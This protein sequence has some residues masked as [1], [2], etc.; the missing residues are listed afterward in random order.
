[1]SVLEDDGN[2]IEAMVAAAAA[3]AVTYPH[4]NALGGDNFWLIHAPG[5][6]VIGIDACG[7][8]AGLA[9]TGYYRDRGHDRI[10]PRG[11]LA[12]LTV[13]GAVS[14]W[15]AALEYGERTWG[16]KLP[17][18]RLLEDP[19]ALA[20]EG[21]AVTRSQ[22]ENT[23]LKLMELKD[24]PG[25]ADAFLDSASIF[26][27]NVITI[28]ELIQQLHSKGV[29]VRLP[30]ISSLSPNWAARLPPSRRPSIMELCSSLGL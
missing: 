2:A 19:I 18:R 7:G 27:F 5:E 16:G 14:G 12:A 8:A 24:A 25:F 29:T 26:H 23:R 28:L 9:D 13:A 11:P 1:M 10:P 30:S 15:S 3:V 17:L 21:I 6:D 22:A 20:G 4:M